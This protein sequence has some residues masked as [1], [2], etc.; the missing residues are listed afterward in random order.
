M[1]IPP[2]I[3]A[4]GLLLVVGVLVLPQAGCSARIIPPAAPPRPQTVL[5]TDYG[6]HSSLVLPDGSGHLV[7][8]AFGDW[9]WFAMGET[10]W[11]GVFEALFWSH[12]STMGI[13]HLHFNADAD[14]LAG[15]I[16]CL[17]VLRIDV[18]AP[19]V[20]KLREQLAHRIDQHLSTMIYN[21]A[22]NYDFVRDDEH[23]SL[24]NNCNHLTARWLVALGCEIEGE[25]I[26]S[27]FTVQPAP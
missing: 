1:T 8:F 6:K 24:W 17:T 4:A 19:D 11:Y 21:P 22:Y 16:G 18:D 14:Q 15:R 2:F 26:T 9:N 7:E 3:R 13:R 23:Y 12:G 20:E 10:H 27:K 5:V 25:P